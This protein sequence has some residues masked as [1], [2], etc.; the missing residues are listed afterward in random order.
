[1]SARIK[2]SLDL[3][4]ETRARLDE[5]SRQT[6]RSEAR[7]ASEAIEE[8]LDRELETVAAVHRGLADQ[9][10]GRVTAHDEVMRRIRATIKRASASQ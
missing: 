6:D 10:A 4:D 8:Y 5:L 3:S 1:M 9:D 2:L 7:L